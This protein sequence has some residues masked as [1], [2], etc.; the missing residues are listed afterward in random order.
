M[1]RNKNFIERFGKGIKGFGA[2]LGTVCVVLL[3][4]SIVV[5]CNS[6][7]K[8]QVPGDGTLDA[9]VELAPVV[10]PSQQQ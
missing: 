7:A 9:G 3:V 5:Q 10:D 1:S 4:V 6:G 2:I 8:I